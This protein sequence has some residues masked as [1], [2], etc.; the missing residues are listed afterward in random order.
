MIWIKSS[1][2]DRLS[3]CRRVVR[4]RF[5]IV[6]PR[7]DRFEYVGPLDNRHP[8]ISGSN[9]ISTSEA[10]RSDTHY[11][12]T[13]AIHNKLLSNNLRVRI[14]M[15]SPKAVADHYRRFR[16]GLFRGSKPRTAL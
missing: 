12:K 11:R 16:D 10:C 7:A 6:Y 13:I 14:E 5:L 15:S 8:H 2:V 1:F 3:R 9:W 4:L